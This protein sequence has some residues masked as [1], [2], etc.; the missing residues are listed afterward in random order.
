MISN[1][2]RS[3]TACLATITLIFGGIA[4]SAPPA[5]SSPSTHRQHSQGANS[6]LNL[7][8]ADLPES[9]TTTSLQPGVTLTTIHRGVV[10][11]TDTW[12][13]E[14]YSADTS[15][16]DPDAPKLAITAEAE[17][18][19]TAVALTAVGL[20]P[21]VEAVRTPRTVDTGGLLGYRTRVG[22]F[23]T[24]ADAAATLATVKAAG[25][26]GSA[27]YTGWDD[28]A[29]A[30]PS[31]GP[32]NLDVITIDP[33]R[34][35]GQLVGDYGKDLFNRD[36]TS[37]L[38]TA[39]GATAA[40]N[41]GFFILDPTAG[42]P[43]DPAG[44]AV[45]KGVIEREAT[46]GRPAFIVD[47]DTGR[48]AIA[49]LWW[50]GSVDGQRHASV[51]LS[52][53]NRVPGLIRNCGEPGD[54]PLAIPQ[55]DVTCTKTSETVAFDNSY[56]AT[57]PSGAGTE[58]VLDAAGR[59][60]SVNS[61]RGISL[62]AGDRSVQ[63]IGADAAPLARLATQSRRLQISSALFTQSGHRLQL[64]SDET[65]VNGAPELVQDG[66]IHATPGQD[67]AVHPGQPNYYYG[68]AHK[69]NPRTFV[70]IDAQGRT[71]LV[72]ADGRST[73]SLGL[74][75]SEEAA[76]A[77]SLGLRDA[78]NLDGG[79]STTAAIDGSVINAPS[80]ATGER[81]VGD[82]LEVLPPA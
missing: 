44:V 28:D 38:A 39:A 62:P 14:V 68:W 8:A 22:S 59:I 71:V 79:G 54:L 72:T 1:T 17:A 43:G 50:R 3:G 4:V 13:V 67:G 7:G 23:T 27:V 37:S 2:R 74:S 18:D 25:F 76:V 6:V 35:T 20:T 5:F 12:T 33:K 42:A 80:D 58:V 75:I 30:A 77:K 66:R 24:S 65:I 40:I 55:Q 21:R 73:N 53:L 34:F 26:N 41:A 29:G 69:R 36:T 70:G 51:T 57:T 82:V 31:D 61:T 46:N 48:S 64:R 15:N 32:W 60:L 19:Q 47:G 78:M 56:G 52:G 45:Y 9:R 11:T 63:A 49:R 16:P 81:P 10:D